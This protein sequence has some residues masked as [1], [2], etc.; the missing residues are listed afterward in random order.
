M[1]VDRIH[2]PLCKMDAPSCKHCYTYP[3]SRHVF[4]VPLVTV[5]VTIVTNSLI[6]QMMI[7]I[8]IITIISIPVRYYYHQ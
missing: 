6:I 7:L 2:Q 4:I 8:A 3:K 1:D 5:I